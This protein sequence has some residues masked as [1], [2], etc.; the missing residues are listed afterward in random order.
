VLIF[1]INQK[2]T[3]MKKFLIPFIAIVFLTG[4]S[5]SEKKNIEKEKAAII[6]IIE[7]STNASYARD[8]K[9]M[10]TYVQDESTIRIGINK[11][12]YHLVKG[13]S[14]LDAGYKKYFKDNP[15]P[16]THKFKKTDYQIKV[17]EQA[18]WSIHNQLN[19]DTDGNETKQIIVHFLEKVEGKWKIS[20]ISVLNASS[21]E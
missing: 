3:V 18:A 10:D 1:S 20:Y 19:T 8:I 15:N 21:F 5:F 6:E 4:T 14:N 13:W 2:L 12:G 17:Y 9:I 11:D 16:A 7:A